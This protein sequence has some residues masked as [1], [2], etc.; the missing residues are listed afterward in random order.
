[1]KL[2]YLG[3]SKDSFKWDYLDSLVSHLRVPFLNVLLMLTPDDRS[4]HGETKA[5]WFPARESV[6]RFCR[7]IK[8]ARD[9]QAIKALPS[10]TGASYQVKLHQRSFDSFNRIDSFAGVDGEHNQ[11]VFADPDNGF[12]PEKSCGH[13]HVAYSDV[14]RILEQLNE[15]SVLTV[16]HHFRRM[17]FPADFARIRSR[18]GDSAS[19]AIYWHSLMFVTIAKSKAA[20]QPVIEANRKYS[21]GHPVKVIT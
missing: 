4:R 5:E 17:S 6:L 7:D 13:E 21:E 11:V 19:T 14:A 15:N 9:I 20:L 3:D 8:A 18:L 12:E 10:Y 16:F 1:M 2:Q